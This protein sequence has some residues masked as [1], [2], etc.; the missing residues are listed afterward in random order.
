[1]LHVVPTLCDS[2]VL[3]LHHRLVLARGAVERVQWVHRGLGAGL[4]RGPAQWT[5]QAQ[6]YHLV[7]L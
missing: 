6:T 7:C 4:A 3:G 1:M 5:A 2:S